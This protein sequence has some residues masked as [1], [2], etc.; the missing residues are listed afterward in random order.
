[1]ALLRNIVIGLRSLFRK[2]HVDQELDEELHVYLE[3]ATDEKMK[4]GMS[5]NDAARAVRWEHGSSQV[6][7][8]IV[9]GASW[10]SFVETSLKDL[11]FAARMLRKNPGFAAIAI[12]TLALGIG[13]NT[14]IYSVV[15]GVVLAPLPYPDPDR[16]VLIR[17]NNPAL[18]HLVWVSYPDFLDW[19]RNAR[20]F[21]Q[22]AALRWEQYNLTSPGAPEHLNGKAVS[23]GFFNTLGVKLSLGREFAPQEDKQGGA[24]VVII[25]DRLWRDRFHG[26]VEALGKSVAL[27]GVAYTIVGVASVGFRFEGETDIYVPAGQ[28]NPLLFNDRTIPI[29]LC[30]ARLKVGVTVAQ[31]AAEL[32]VVQ[33]NLDR[34]YPVANRGL[35]IDIAPLKQVVVG[36][37]SGTLLLL[38]GAVAV[39]LLIAC[40][41]VANLLLA[42]S[43]ARKREFAIRSA[44][45]ASRARIVLQLVTESVLLSLAG[46][47]IGL[48]VAKWGL[49]AV[50]AAAPETL[51]R[52]ENIGVNV[53]VLFFTFGISLAVGILFGLAPAIK[54][55]K[56]ELQT[57]L[58]EG[59]RGS[60]GAHH[61]AQSGLV[62]VQMALTL[63]L[64]AGAG[65]LFRT[66]HR[67]WDVNPGFDPRD[68]V[69][70]KVGLS[71][72]LTKTPRVKQI[73]YKQLVERIRQIPGVQA[74]D[75]TVLVPMGHSSNSGPFLVESQESASIAEAPRAQF[76]WTGP[77]YLGTMG[78][79]LLKGRYFAP[80]DTTKS[81]P[82]VVIDSVLAHTYFPDRD[83]VGQ[84]LTIPHWRAARIIGV[85]GHVQHWDLGNFNRYIQNAIYA[86]LYQIPDE[87]I[88]NFYADL[89][90]TVRTPV[91]AATLIPMVK[92]AIYSV[93]DS[94]PIYNVQT[95]EELISQS[96]SA[97]RFPMIL[98][99][100]FACL[101]LLL[102]SVG[103]YGVISYS[104][105]QR[106]H[107][108]GIRKALGAENADIFRM[109]IDHGLRLALTSLAIGTAAALILT[110]LLSSF[111]HLLYGVKTSDPGTFMAI[112]LLLIGV[113]LLACY[114]PAR[115]ATH[116][117]PMVAL[118]YE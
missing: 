87:W 7:K 80:E 57:S 105:A 3:M 82:V 111:S 61:R 85:V 113:A 6:T 97:Q 34:L 75:L 67:L 114:I 88:A 10:E 53:S 30:V 8:E 86:S 51:P 32:G 83:P 100:A 73:A 19:Q 116:V 90:V 64:L 46:G 76:Y 18:Q 33:E 65:L 92:A 68:V 14:A 62:I 70:F 17:E 22:I 112:S 15:Q 101:A 106:V 11:R 84:T 45:G 99:G 52:S 25:S 69:T 38:L 40:A 96:M 71:P 43:A 93:D 16:L 95:M 39:V 107:E 89:T 108:I 102:A 47:G 117:D 26:S 23:T 72:S 91:E 4:E 31:A 36:D 56:S 74:A 27:D 104:V 50:L 54:S 41:N 2:K 63:V 58:K 110:R 37:V 103:I 77:E 9:H 29:I 35:G 59:G 94:Q 13:A 109:V 78:I 28:G 79:P 66:I 48:L 12:L 20:S 118:R 21:Q 49:G 24:P 44:L 98:L 42:R 81:D 115:R 5:R 1:M 55:S 60:T